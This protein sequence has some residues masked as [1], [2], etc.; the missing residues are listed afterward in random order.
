MV[1]SHYRCQNSTKRVDKV[2]NITFVTSCALTLNR[3]HHMQCISFT[4]RV[5]AHQ[6][7]SVIYANAYLHVISNT[8]ESFAKVYDINILILVT[9]VTYGARK[10]THSAAHRVS[11]RRNGIRQRYKS[12]HQNTNSSHEADQL[13]RVCT[14]SEDGSLARPH[15]QP[16]TPA[17][18]VPAITPAATFV[19]HRTRTAFHKSNRERDRQRAL[20]GMGLAHTAPWSLTFHAL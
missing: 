15:T 5:K 14:M 19:F 8:T 3:H 18:P 1:S 17:F 4:M 13:S 9:C 11:K 6:G 12:A 7:S 20:H 16:V 2:I 10:V